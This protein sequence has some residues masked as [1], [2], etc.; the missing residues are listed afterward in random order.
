MGLKEQLVRIKE[1]TEPQI[2][3]EITPMRLRLVQSLRK[4]EVMDRVLKVGDKMP[5]FILPNA[6][7][8][9]V[10]SSELLAKGPLVTSFFLGKW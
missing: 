8:R 10:T 7:G 6:T 3:P 2:P 4:P 5:S 1:R 9:M